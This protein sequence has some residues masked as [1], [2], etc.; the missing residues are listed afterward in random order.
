MSEQ[1]LASPDQCHMMEGETLF[2][3]CTLSLDWFILWLLGWRE[4]QGSSVKG[5]E[6]VT[7]KL[8]QKHLFV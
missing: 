8:K 5:N 3:L 7:L 4:G 2:F 1:P 6:R